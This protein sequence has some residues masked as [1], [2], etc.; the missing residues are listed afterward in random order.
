MVQ[1]MQIEDP[2]EW[3]DHL[4]DHLSVACRYS[5]YPNNDEVVATLHISINSE[6]LFKSL[7]IIIS[8]D[9]LTVIF[10]RLER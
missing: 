9:Q 10:H 6:T 8:N 4:E 7:S 2:I 5:C 1:Q 3:K